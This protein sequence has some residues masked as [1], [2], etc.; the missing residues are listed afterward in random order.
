[1]NHAQDLSCVEP[2]LTS[3]V[4]FLKYCS[5]LLLVIPEALSQVSMFLEDVFPL[6]QTNGRLA[7]AK[8]DAHG[9]ILLD[10]ATAALLEAFAWL[11]SGS[12]PL[13]AD[14]VFTFAEEQIRKSV[15]EGVMCSILDSLIAKQ[16]TMLESKPFCRSGKDSKLF[17]TR[18][19]EDASRL[20]SGEVA[21]YNERE[22]V[23]HLQSDSSVKPIAGSESP[24]CNS[25]ILEYFTNDKDLDNKPPTPLHEVGT[26]RRPV[27]PMFSCRVRLVD[28]AIQAFSATFGLKDGKEQ[29]GAMNLLE[30]L[31]PPSL[32]NFSR[33]IG[34]SSAPTD[35]KRSKVC[36]R[37]ESV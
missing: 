4:V 17:G 19:F 3:V 25:S 12:F 24:F 16:D 20:V 34:I 18:D 13:V 35:E 14:E 15:E 7:N 31:L 6:L 5:E 10:N 32:C 28:A 27:D 1:M 9:K 33:A 23:F 36:L 21:L 37:S 2:A 30:I 26:W 22:S 11:P 29:Q 8:H